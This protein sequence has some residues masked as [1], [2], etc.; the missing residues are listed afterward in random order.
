MSADIHSSP[1]TAEASLKG[2][3][4]ALLR[5]DTDERDRLCKRAEILLEAENYANAVEAVLSVDFYVFGNGTVI[6]TKEM[7]KSVGVLV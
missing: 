6:P 3:F 5:G 4:A 1:K 2:A 7:A